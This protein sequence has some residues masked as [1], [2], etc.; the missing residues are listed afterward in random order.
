MQAHYKHLIIDPLDNP[1]DNP[2]KTRPIQMG[3]EIVSEPYPN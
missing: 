1:L 3:K 2:L